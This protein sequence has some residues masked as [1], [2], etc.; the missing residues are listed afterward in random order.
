MSMLEIP[1]QFWLTRRYL[2]GFLT[3]EDCARNHY[4]EDYLGRRFLVD[5][6]KGKPLIEGVDFVITGSNE[7]RPEDITIPPG[8]MEADPE[9]NEI[10]MYLETWFD[11]EKKFQIPLDDDSWINFYVSYFLPENQLRLFYQVDSLH[12][13]SMHE[14]I[15]TTAE[16]DLILDK[17]RS[18]PEF[19]QEFN[20]DSMEVT[21]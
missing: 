21:Q 10:S 20:T 2:T 3:M 1:Q 14:Y 19:L 17:I 9:K 13:E 18:D 4:P 8:E 15:P 16:R 5:R 11:A 7:I 12:D 6:K